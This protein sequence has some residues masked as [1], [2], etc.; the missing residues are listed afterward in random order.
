[1]KSASVTK[2][3]TIKNTKYT[4]AAPYCLEIELKP[5]FLAC[6]SPIRIKA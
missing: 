5:L 6:Y 4:G 2:A 3:A 1:M